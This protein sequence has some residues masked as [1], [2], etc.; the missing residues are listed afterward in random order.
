MIVSQ[1][2]ILDV[3]Q[4]SKL[5]WEFSCHIIHIGVK[6]SQTGQLSYFC[7]KG[8]IDPVERDVEPFQGCEV[9]YFVGEWAF[10]VIFCEAELCKQCEDDK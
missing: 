9:E 10:N 5:G 6:F 3:N 8:S 1:H 7:R 4:I 2:K